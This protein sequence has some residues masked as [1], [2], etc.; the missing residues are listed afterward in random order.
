MPSLFQVIGVQFEVCNIN[1]AIDKNN[2]GAYLSKSLI[3]LLLKRA[4]VSETN[5]AEERCL[6]AAAER[7]K[8]EI[9]SSDSIT[10]IIELG[11]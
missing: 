3:P 6:F 2:G 9:N 11:G 10:V 1:F 5:N 7:V 4:E 8:F